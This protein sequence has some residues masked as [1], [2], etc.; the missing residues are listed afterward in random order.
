[1]RFRV[2][3]VQSDGNLHFVQATA[4]LDEAKILVSELG[5]AWPGEY[6]IENEETG[7]R[8]VVS[9]RDETKN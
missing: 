6:V 3:K 8:L 5:E 2:F 4:S 7:D 9:T 1:V